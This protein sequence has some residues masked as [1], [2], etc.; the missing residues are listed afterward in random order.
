[1]QG[2]LENL[3]FWLFYA[4]IYNDGQPGNVYYFYIMYF[5]QL[6]GLAYERLCIRWLT[7]RF[8]CNYFYFQKFVEL[9]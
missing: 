8:G 7:D 3:Q 4:G 5:L 2:R 1:M 9:D 6:A